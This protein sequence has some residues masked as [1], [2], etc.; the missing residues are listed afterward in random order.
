MSERPD[1][2]RL[3]GAA[4]TEPEPLRDVVRDLRQATLSE[5]SLARIEAKL[6]AALDVRLPA[7]GARRAAPVGGPAA[8]TGRR[9]LWLVAAALVV[10]VAAA[11]AAERRARRTPPVQSPAGLPALGAPASLPP[12]PPVEPTSP[13]T[14]T[15]DG[16]LDASAVPSRAS[17][18]PVSAPSE[19]ELLGRAERS[20]ASSPATAL[21]LADEHARRFPRG[22]LVQ[23]R[24]VIA[25][26][27]LARLGR[28][29]EAR[30]RGRALLRAYPA[31][32]YRTKVE[33]VLGPS[34]P[35]DE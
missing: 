32:I 10:A 35:P 24:E 7:P 29:A 19:G 16:E 27:A 25:V 12:P 21:A 23:E 13:P 31:S 20:L 5:Q 15:A 28:E 2:P 11:L 17:S 22:S 14:A 30:A 3:T 6:G 4:S 34:A 1:P 33:Q 18:P 8:A 26:E 9:W